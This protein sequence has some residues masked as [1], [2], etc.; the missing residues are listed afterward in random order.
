MVRSPLEVEKELITFVRSHGGILTNTD[1]MVLTGVTYR[2]AD[3]IGT[4]LVATYGGAMDLVDDA[5]AIYRFP[6]LTPHAHA[7]IE[8]SEP[9]LRRVWELRLAA[10]RL[11]MVPSVLIPALNGFNLVLAMM[12]K[13]K[14]MMKLDLFPQV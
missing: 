5:L 2:E 10:H 7:A 3:R 9:S 14:K 4:R 1:I 12:M 13:L 11:V 6:D 8:R